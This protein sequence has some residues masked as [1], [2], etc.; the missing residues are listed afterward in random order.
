LFHPSS[1]SLHPYFEVIMA[2]KSTPKNPQYEAMF[3]LGPVAGSAEDVTVLPKGIIERHGGEIMVIKKWDERKLAYELGGQKRG[4]YV[5]AFFTAPGSAITQIERDVNLSDEI[6]RVMVLQA[7]HLAKEEM[8]A[9][10]PQ[11]PMP[12]E[13]KPIWDASRWEERPERSERS[14]GGR[15]RRQEETAT[16]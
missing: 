5:V 14:G 10:E 9:V 1:F 3:L 7:D 11:K 15:G 16:E 6:T 4:T 13:E 12:V 2:K 8:E